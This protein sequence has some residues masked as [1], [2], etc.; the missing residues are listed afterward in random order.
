VA[1]ASSTASAFGVGICDILDYTNTNKNRVTR[2][3]TGYDANGSGNSRLY[4]GL[5][6][7]TTTVTSI[8][9]WAEPGSLHTEYSSFALYGI[10]G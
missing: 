5:Y 8:K 9:L 7:S 4:S 3:L 1:G 10:K 6:V 2:S